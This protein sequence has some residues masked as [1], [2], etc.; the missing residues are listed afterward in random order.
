[1]ALS[2]ASA[3]AVAGTETALWLA[4]EAA[5]FAVPGRIEEVTLALAD[6]AEAF[7]VVAD[8]GEVRVCAPCAARREITPDDLMPGARLGGAAELAEA[9]LQPGV[10]ALVY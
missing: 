8:F 2:V 7:R 1:M 9:L 4:G 3:A 10:Q 5:W 6:P